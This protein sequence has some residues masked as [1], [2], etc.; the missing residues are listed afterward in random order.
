M[1]LVAKE[2]D[3][4]LE[5]HLVD[6]ADRFV[7][8]IARQLDVLDLRAKPRRPFDDICAGDDVVDCNCLSHGCASRTCDPNARQCSAGR[9]SLN[10]MAEFKRFEFRSVRFYRAEILSPLVDRYFRS[11]LGRHM[12]RRA[13]DRRRHRATRRNP[14]GDRPIDPCFMGLEIGQKQIAADPC[15]DGRDIPLEAQDIADRQPEAD[16][17]GRVEDMNVLQIRRA[18]GSFSRNSDPDPR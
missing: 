5:Q 12:V 4:V 10:T 7:G 2:D 3:L 18:A 14:Q 16:E 15:H 11:L 1:V 6:R 8:Q 13:P 9:R 17:C